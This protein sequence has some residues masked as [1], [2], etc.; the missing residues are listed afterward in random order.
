MFPVVSKAAL[1]TKITPA[2]PHKTFADGLYLAIRFRRPSASAT[3]TVRLPATT[4][5]AATRIEI[6]STPP[7]AANTWVNVTTAASGECPSYFDLKNGR[8]LKLGLAAA[9]WPLMIFG[10]PRG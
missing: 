9:A 6:G 8:G 5:V 3:P 10:F 1:R 7:L 4:T 2:V